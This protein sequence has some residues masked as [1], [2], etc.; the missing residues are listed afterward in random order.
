MQYF[1]LLTTKYSIHSHVPLFTYSEGHFTI[2]LKH[3]GCPITKEILRYALT[4]KWILAQKH[5]TPEIQFA[6]HRKIKKREY[7]C[8]DT[9]FLLRIANKI[10]MKGVIETKFRAKTKGWTNKRLS[11]SGIHPIISYQTKTLLHMLARFC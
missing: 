10:P 7:Q 6:K 5:R 1:T 2:F 11:H 4:D 9:S 3:H 8:M